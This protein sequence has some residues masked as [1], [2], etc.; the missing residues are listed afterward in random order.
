MAHKYD[1]F[2]DAYK[3]L[4]GKWDT[5]RSHWD[6]ILTYKKKAFTAWSAN[7]DHIAIGHLITAITETWF[8][9]NVYP[10][11]QF[12]DPDQSPIVESIYWANKDVPTAEVTMRAILDEMF[13][14]SDYELMQFIAL[15]DAYRQ[16]LWNKPFDANYWA[17]VARGFEQWEF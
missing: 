2:D 13:T 17:A 9:F 4:E 11:F 3:G 16:S 12:S 6:N 15:V 7:E 10:G 5:A 8:T 14:A 1:N